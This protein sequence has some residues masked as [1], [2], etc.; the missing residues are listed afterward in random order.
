MAIPRKDY[1][2]HPYQRLGGNDNLSF[3][4]QGR[5]LAT[6]KDSA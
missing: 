1:K 4:N 6:A 5:P 2:D 3:A